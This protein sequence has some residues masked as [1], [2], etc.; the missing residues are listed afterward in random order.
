[1]EKLIHNSS[2]QM[3]YTFPTNPVFSW[4]EEIEPQVR[5]TNNVKQC[6]GPM[7]TTCIGTCS[8]STTGP[9]IEKEMLKC[10]LYKAKNQLSGIRIW[11][12]FD[13][14]AYVTF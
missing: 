4:L 8:L 1:M 10:L 13:I 7:M 5:F 11:S 9:L 3:N 12:R 14:D 2:I 6:L